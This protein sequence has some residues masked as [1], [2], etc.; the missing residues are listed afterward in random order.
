[1]K[2]IL[3]TG[4]Q[5]TEKNKLL[6]M[7]ISTLNNGQGYKDFN[8]INFDGMDSVRNGFIRLKDAKNSYLSV[9]DDLENVLN[10]SKRNAFNLVLDASFALNTSYGYVP[11]ITERFFSIFKPDVILLLENKLEDFK[12]N[13]RE[14]YSIKEQQEMN[15]FY[16]VKFATHFG[17]PVKIIKVS[18]SEIK[19]TVKEIQNY[20]LSITREA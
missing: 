1:M 10:D 15:K 2:L 11:L 14:F 9:Y 8:H 6:G 7:S 4:I 17:I 5:Q 13:P 12:D 16:C 19:S 20:L 18:R 3:V